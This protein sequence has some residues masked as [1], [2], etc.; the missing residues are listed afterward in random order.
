MI[1]ENREIVPLRTVGLYKGQ[2]IALKSFYVEWT[3]DDC[4]GAGR[5]FNRDILKGI[6]PT[7]A[8][9]FTPHPWYLVNPGNI[10]RDLCFPPQIVY[11]HLACSAPVI[12]GVGS[13]LILVWFQQEE[14][15]LFD[16]A[17][18]HLQKVKWEK[19]AANLSA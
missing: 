17:A 15:V 5:V 9:V 16:R 3:Y 6:G 10:D 14:D 19:W 11:A 12:A 2:D 8:R 4:Y 18:K 1:L 7:V 13:T